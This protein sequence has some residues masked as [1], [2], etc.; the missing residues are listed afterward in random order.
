[1]KSAENLSRDLDIFSHYN[2]NEYL[3]NSETFETFVLKK[4]GQRPG[5]RIV[6]P[7]SKAKLTG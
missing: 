7:D 5:K 3:Q 4:L 2:N 6:F 1:M